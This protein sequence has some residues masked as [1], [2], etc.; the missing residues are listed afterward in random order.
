MSR[1]WMGIPGGNNEQSQP[2]IGLPGTLFGGLMPI[3]SSGTSVNNERHKRLPC[4]KTFG[5]AKNTSLGGKE[6][7]RA[8]TCECCGLEHVKQELFV[9]LFA[10][11][12]WA[13]GLTWSVGV[14]GCQCSTSWAMGNPIRTRHTEC[15]L[16]C[17]HFDRWSHLSSFPGPLEPLCCYLKL[18][19]QRVKAG[20]YP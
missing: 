4:L 13:V 5:K 14:V 3:Y 20:S 17:E 7:Q 12:A 6:A 8:L 19:W 15:L 18:M 16:Y 1:G 2:P 11:A 10:L 9:M